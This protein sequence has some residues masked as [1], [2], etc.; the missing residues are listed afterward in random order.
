MTCLK[1]NFF[2]MMEENIKTREGSNSSD[3]Q[4]GFSRQ[5]K[6]N[7]HKIFTLI[8]FCHPPIQNKHEIH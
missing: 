8:L 1:N 5:V 7:L 4:V 6:N 2:D 3:T